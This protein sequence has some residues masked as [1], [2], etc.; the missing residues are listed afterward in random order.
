VATEHELQ[1]GEQVDVRRR[2]YEIVGLAWKRGREY[3]MCIPSAG[4]RAADKPLG[5]E[6]AC[7]STDWR[8][9]REE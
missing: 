9:Q 3:L 4:S 1:L 8:N 6:R 5:K 2:S 7:W